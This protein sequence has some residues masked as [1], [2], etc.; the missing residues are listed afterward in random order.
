MLLVFFTTY[1]TSFASWR[2]LSLIQTVFELRLRVSTLNNSI[3]FSTTFIYLLLFSFGSTLCALYACIYVDAHAIVCACTWRPEVSVRHVPLSPSPDLLRWCLSLATD[4][5]PRQ[6][7]ELQ[8]SV[9]FSLGAHSTPA[10]M[11]VPSIWTL[12]LLFT[13]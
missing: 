9:C 6:A 5:P 10:I 1:N 4:W 8:G 13:Q 11:N 2:T 3:T 12:I 7:T